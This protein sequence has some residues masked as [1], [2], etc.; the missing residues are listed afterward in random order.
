MS[1]VTSKNNTYG[2]SNTRAN[3]N[4]NS[5]SQQKLKEN[6]QNFKES[7]NSKGVFIEEIFKGNFSCESTRK[8]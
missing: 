7:Q 6:I 8:C 5:V 4:A 3:P 1:N 2:V